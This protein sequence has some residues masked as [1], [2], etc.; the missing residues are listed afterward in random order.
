DLK[1]N[2]NI[3]VAKDGSGNVKTLKEAIAA[4]PDNSKTRYV[5][6]VKK[7]IYDEVVNIRKTNLTIVGDGKNLTIL[8]GNL[9]PKDGAIGTFDTATLA[10]DGDG[11]LAQDICIRNTAGPTK[12]QTVALR[13]SSDRVVIHRCRIEAFQDTLYAHSHRQFY[14][15]CYITGTIDFICGDATAVFQYCQIEPRNPIRSH[16]N[17]ITAQKWNDTSESTGFVFQKCNIT[18]SKDL[19]PIKKKVKTYL[20]RPWGR[21]SRVVFMESFIDDL[22]E[23]EGY[24]PMTSDVKR[25]STLSY[26]EYKNTGPGADTSKRVKWKG[27]KVITDPKEAAKFTV[28]KFLQGNLWINSTGVPYDNGF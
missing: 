1:R 21:L 9:N 23:P 18:A 6:Y 10:V 17:I 8:T 14:R 3:V 24:K 19:V 13:V 20:G 4:A 22:I 12:G 25:L 16:T 27:F 7:G 26:R 11:F 15:G 2:A 28:G 5:I